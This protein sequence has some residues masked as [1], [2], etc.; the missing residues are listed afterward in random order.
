MTDFHAPLGED[1]RDGFCSDCC[2]APGEHPVA[3]AVA[4]CDSKYEHEVRV[5][6]EGE[7]AYAYGTGPAG[8]DVPAVSGLAP[9][10]T[11]VPTGGAV[12]EAACPQTVGGEPCTGHVRWVLTADDYAAPMPEGFRRLLAAYGARIED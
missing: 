5:I 7:T 9:T 3:T 4:Y 10:A 11:E 6:T 8:V 12:L 1:A 2:H